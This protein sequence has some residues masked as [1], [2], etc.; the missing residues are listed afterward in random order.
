MGVGRYLP[1]LDGLRT[2]AVLLVVGTHTGVLPGGYIGV[3]VFFV[4]SGYLITRLI[5]RQRESGEWSLRAFYTRRMRRLYPALGLLLLLVIPLA[6]VLVPGSNAHQAL[7]LMS[8][9]TYTSD[10]VAGWNVSWLGAV[11]HT[12]SLAL[13]E[14]FY[15]LWPLVLPSAVSRNG[16][17][18]L[19]LL[20]S[21][22]LIYLAAAGHVGANYVP[23]G[24]GAIIL[25]GCLLAL[26]PPA[27]PR[28]GL[29]ATVSTLL[30]AAT[31]VLA[32]PAGSAQEGMASVAAG[33]ASFGLIA[34][35][36]QSRCWLATSLQARPLVWLGER[37]YGIYLFHFPI[38][39][40]LSGQ[41]RLVQLLATVGGAVALAAFSHRYVEARFRAPRGL[42]VGTAYN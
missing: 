21:L 37:S 20:T 10:L 33:I 1:Q 17:R 28:P 18:G 24:R 22:M 23:P 12:W 35:V 29:V 13:E 25:L 8:A 14:Q 16:K 5:L 27:L 42:V 34:S 39:F 19:V 15:L 6:N 31:V 26:R 40:A 9:A 4:L 11:K 41:P 32:P 36:L 7:A 3:D 38:V 2:V 30:L